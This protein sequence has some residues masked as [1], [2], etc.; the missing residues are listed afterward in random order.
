MLAKYHPLWMNLHFNHPNEITPEVA[1]ACDKLTRAGIPLGNQSVLL[2]GVN[3]CV[4]IMRAL[5]HKLVENRIRPYYIY[6]CDLVEGSGHFRTPVGKGLEIME[7]LRGHTSGYAVPTYVVD[8]PGGGGKIPVM[9][10]YLISYSDHKVVLRN[11]EGYITT[12]EEPIELHAA[13]PGQLPATASTRARSRARAAS[14]ACSRAT[15]CGSSRPASSR[16]TAAA[17]STAHR[18]Q[19][20]AKWVPYGVGPIEG[21]AGQPLPALEPGSNSQ[22]PVDAVAGGA[23]EAPVPETSD[24]ASPDAPGAAREPGS[25][26]GPAR[27]PV[28]ARAS[29]RAG[30][31][32]SRS[33]PKPQRGSAGRAHAVG[34]ISRPEAVRGPGPGRA[35]TSGRRMP[36]AISTANP[37]FDRSRCCQRGS[38]GAAAGH[39]RCGARYGRGRWPQR[40]LRR[41]EQPGSCARPM[42]GRRP[43]RTLRPC[44]ALSPS[45]GA[46]SGACAG[47]RTTPI[48]P[49][50]WS[51]PPSPRFTLA[52]DHS[53]LDPVSGIAPRCC[54]RCRSPSGAA[55]RCASSS[56][57]ARRSPC[58]ACSAT[59]TRTAASASSWPSTRSPPTSPGAGRSS[60]PRSRPPA[61]LVSFAAYA[62][63]N[64]LSG[65]TAG[66]TSTYLSFGLA[67]LIGDNLRVR[68]AY[69]RR[70]GGASRAASSASARRRRPGRGRGTGPH[71]PRAA[72]RRRPLRQR[73]GRPG[74][75]SA[76]GRSTRIRWRLETALE[77]V[78]AAGRT[79]L[80][81]MR[82]MLEVL[83]TDDPGIGPAARPGRAGQA[84]RAGPRRRPAG[85]ADGRGRRM[86]PP[87]RHGPG[88]VPDRPGSP[89]QHGQ[90]RRQG[91][92]PGDHSLRSGQRSRSRWSTTAA[93][94]PRRCS[95]ARRVAATA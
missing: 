79:A 2:A 1:R 27:S 70:A 62:I 72:R 38:A 78:E 33:R 59:P 25:S 61:I 81:E 63:I 80:A 42:R 17:T 66:L 10:N 53:R 48:S 64:S 21:T 19:D 87:A 24:P 91:D 54:R 55:T 95:P 84:D 11:Y 7:G 28:R 85:R 32:A 46:S 8:A 94:P 51:W 60:P 58:T 35:R 36:G 41:R 16:R 18:L 22:A 49:W 75:R 57:P 39:A 15:A 34:R 77:A 13:R 31:T 74:G 69:T 83:R 68:R 23:P 88:G 92:G 40:S 14:R 45:R 6:Q 37:P 89:D 71:R 9:P 20:P 73:H 26:T 52:H 29:P 3:D 93:E 4:H 43:R 67:W 44:N 12:Y 90:A 56:S 5:V 65:W 82:R 76:A 86:L 30:P 50:L 47:T